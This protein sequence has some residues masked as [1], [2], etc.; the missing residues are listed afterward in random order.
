MREFYSSRFLLGFRMD[1]KQ[2]EKQLNKIRSDFLLRKAVYKFGNRLS[3]RMDEEDF[4]EELHPREKDGKFAPKGSGDKGASKPTSGGGSAVTGTTPKKSNPRISSTTRT[5][6]GVSYPKLRSGANYSSA[7]DV[8]E[9]TARKDEENGWIPKGTWDKVVSSLKESDVVYQ[10]NEDGDTIA[11]IPGLAAMVDREI[12]GSDTMKDIHRR[13]I[14][15]GARIQK[16]LTAVAQDS[17]FYLDGLENCIK[18]ASHLE[19]KAKRK[20]DKFKKDYGDDYTEDDVAENL[21]D[22]VRF[23][24]VTNNDNIVDGTKK[25]IKALTKQGYEVVEVDNKFLNKDG[26][27]NDD[28]IY[29]AVHLSVMDKNGRYFELQV[30]SKESLAVK[31][32][33]HKEYERQR[34]FEKIPR[35]QW[36]QWMRKEDAKLSEI[37]RK[38]WKS[39][40]T[41]PRGIETL[42]SIPKSDWRPHKV[43]KIVN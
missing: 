16:D 25:M 29:R 2:I 39:S 38:R 40:Y 1:Q 20:L 8:A 9:E 24:A 7:L 33:N 21:W 14:E 32:L 13:A 23:T 31:A 22:S 36:P 10:K 26:S 3:N 4:K 28:A 5:K 15:D 41:N 37:Q 19:D 34:D 35:D 27:V 30:H 6:T 17:G 18:G 11:C 43:K 42:Q 12:K